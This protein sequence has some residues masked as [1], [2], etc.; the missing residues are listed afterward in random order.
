MPIRY[1]F[2]TS[3]FIKL[4]ILEP[5]T[6]VAQGYFNQASQIAVSRL[7]VVETE[8]ALQKRFRDKSLT[9]EMLGQAQKIALQI[10]PSLHFLTVDGTLPL[11]QS[12]LQTAGPLRTLDAIHLATAQMLAVPM[13][14]FDRQLRQAALRIGVQIL[15]Y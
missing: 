5:E 8:S 9:Q 7:L 14:V 15:P 4:L 11:A 12:L 6:E 2:D 13:I 1:V 3:A 10:L